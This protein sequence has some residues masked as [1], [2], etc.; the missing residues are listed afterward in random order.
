MSYPG[1]NQPR[2]AYLEPAHA[3]HERSAF[4]YG[5]EYCHHFLPESAEIK[6]LT[7]QPWSMRVSIFHMG[8]EATA[9][10]GQAFGIDSRT[11]AR[12]TGRD[13]TGV[14]AAKS[15]LLGELRHCPQCLAKGWHSVLFQ[16][17]A[18]D[19]CPVHQTPL[20]VG[21]PHC[22]GPI[23]TSMA[24]IG[25][26]H[27]HCPNCNRAL[28]VERRREGLG[29]PVVQ[30]GAN[31]FASLRAS[32]LDTGASDLI[33]SP[34]QLMD[35]PD[36]M[37]QCPSA[38][39]GAAHHLRWPSLSN[40][41]E[42]GIERPGRYDTVLSVEDGAAPLSAGQRHRRL[43]A[44]ALA[45]VEELLQ[46]AKEEGAA[47]QVPPPLT[48]LGTAASRVDVS[49]GLVAAALWRTAHIFKVATFLLGEMPPPQADEQPLA[50]GVPPFAEVDAAVRRAQVQDLFVE[51]LIALRR[52]RFGIEVDWNRLP[53]SHRMTP[54]WR[55]AVRDGTVEI[56]LRS[57]S[58]KVLA[59]R[60]IRRYRDQALALAPDGIK[61]ESLLVPTAY[62]AS[63]DVRVSANLG[64]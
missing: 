18:V 41:P 48:A 9:A 7:S 17:V 22:A 25:K 56:R 4:M 54:A 59:A 16:H 24:A 52:R 64:P 36:Q 5:V 50:D 32:L 27:L 39:R 11:W 55:G 51:S 58:N 63:A 53:T 44:A 61:P 31:L 28:A 57:R 49:V 38:V 37:V 62:G 33:R 42:E 20:Q 29:Q 26:N 1:T 3:R 8:A 43:R 40:G 46:L 2:L 15:V 60:L 6:E 30:I 35:T 45:G 21:C 34:L 23:P 13:L 14:H 19:R 10:L 47:M 12:A